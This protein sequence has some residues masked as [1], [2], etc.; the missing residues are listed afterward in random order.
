LHALL[1]ARHILHV[2]RIRVKIFRQ[3][4]RVF[5]PYRKVFKELKRKTEIEAGSNHNVSAKKKYK[6]F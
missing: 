6:K 3:L 4:E 5:E 1:E 2:S